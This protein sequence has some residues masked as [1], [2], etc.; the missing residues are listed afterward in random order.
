MV[1]VNK[2]YSI[3]LFFLFILYLLFAKQIYVNKLKKTEFPKIIAT[4]EV[5]L[6]SISDPYTKVENAIEDN[7]YI[8]TWLED[9]IK[10]ENELINYLTN[11]ASTYD[12]VHASVI[13]DKSLTYYGSDKVVG[14]DSTNLKRDGWYF[15]YRNSTSAQKGESIFYIDKIYPKILTIFINIP[16][17]NEQGKY[18]GVAGGGF[19]YKNFDSYLNQLERLYNIEMFLINDSTI[20][21]SNNN[22]N[23]EKEFKNLNQYKKITNGVFLD[24]S[25]DNSLTFIK[26]LSKWDSYLIVKRSNKQIIKEVLLEIAHAIIFITIIIVI[27]SVINS[28]KIIKNKSKEMESKTTKEALYLNKKITSIVNQK[29]NSYKSKS[30]LNKEIVELLQFGYKYINLSYKIIDNK[31]INKNE[32][33]NLTTLIKNMI[34]LELPSLLITDLKIDLRLIQEPILVN[35]DKE[36]FS[37]LVKTLILL[38]FYETNY[39]ELIV[40]QEVYKNKIAV[41]LIINNPTSTNVIYKIDNIFRRLFSSI[42]VQYKKVLNTTGFKKTEIIQLIFEN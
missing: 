18:I 15:D 31:N 39:K 2:K 24:N 40:Y 1:K 21:Y 4:M 33:C 7:N 32:Y 9:S 17:L 42:N 38:L 23:I 20:I 41:N 6:N 8:Q 28:H 13:D 16:I 12:L 30:Y 11:L 37:I 34:L 26:Y 3:I 5:N 29:V 22:K 25:G 19:Y 10:D 27:V 14:L 36:K 35:I